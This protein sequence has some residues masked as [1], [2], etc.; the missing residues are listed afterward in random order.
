MRTQ[1]TQINQLRERA[2]KAN[3]ILKFK[4]QLNELLRS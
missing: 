4:A 3:S 2:R 1:M